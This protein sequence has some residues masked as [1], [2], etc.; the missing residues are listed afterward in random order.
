MIAE[1]SPTTTRSFWSARSYRRGLRMSSVLWAL[2]VLVWGA[3]CAT[4]A[5]PRQAVTVSVYYATTRAVVPNAPTQEKAFSATTAELRDVRY[6]RALVELAPSGSRIVSYDPSL[7]APTGL[8][9]GK[10]DREVRSQISA[11]HPLIV[12][13]HGYNNTFATAAHRAALFAHELQPDA[14]EKPAI[15]SWPSAS[16]LLAYSKDEE[17]ALLNQENIRRF[18]TGLHNDDATTPAVL[19]GHSLGARALTYGLRDIFLFRA[20]SGIHGIDP[21]R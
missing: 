15:Y 2:F 5:G 21:R 18:L 7:A 16:K 19:I 14:A 4:P 1:H 8:L 13:I 9:P 17:T 6:G 12:Y 3:G 10:F 20:G 11:A